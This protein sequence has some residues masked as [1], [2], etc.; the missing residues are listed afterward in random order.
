MSLRLK[1]F[2]PWVAA[3]AAAGG[4]VNEDGDEAGV[5][6]V[7]PVDSFVAVPLVSVQCRVVLFCVVSDHNIKYM[8]DT[9]VY[10]LCKARHAGEHPDHL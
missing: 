6:V 10:V 5:S 4:G 8:M 7:F 2:W 9:R 1:W 3:R